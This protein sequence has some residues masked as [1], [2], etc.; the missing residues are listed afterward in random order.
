MLMY[1]QMV[2]VTVLMSSRSSA[3]MCFSWTATFAVTWYR[4]SVNAKML[5]ARIAFGRFVFK[6]SN[7]LRTSC[8]SKSSSISFPELLSSQSS[9]DVLIKRDDSCSYLSPNS[10]IFTTSV[11][12]ASFLF[13]FIRSIRSSI[14]YTGFKFFSLNLLT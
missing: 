9:L 8:L 12:D 2:I 7:G 13:L 5:I 3:L 1:A 14:L 4:N 10:D 11:V 6:L